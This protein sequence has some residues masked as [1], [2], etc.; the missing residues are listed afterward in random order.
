MLFSGWHHVA[1]VYFTKQCSASTCVRSKPSALARRTRT[2]QHSRLQKSPDIA[3][4]NLSHPCTHIA[5]DPT[6][7][8]AGH[9]DAK[10]AAMFWEQEVVKKVF[11]ERRGWLHIFRTYYGVVHLVLLLF[12]SVVVFTFVGLGPLMGRTSRSCRQVRGGRA[13]VLGSTGRVQCPFPHQRCALWVWRACTRPS[14][15]LWAWLGGCVQDRLRL[16]P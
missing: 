11:V 2:L 6:V 12:Q 7:A 14:V 4:A 10:A 9:I 3:A 5:D 8:T 1:S 15:L 16:S 13:V